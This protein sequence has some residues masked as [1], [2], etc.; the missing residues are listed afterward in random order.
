VHDVYAYGL[1]AQSTLCTLEGY[2]PARAGYAEIAKVAEVGHTVGGE[3]TGSAYV[4]ARLGVGTKLDGSW[5]GTDE[6]SRQVIGLL[7][8]AGVDCS[9]IRLKDDAE[10]IRE[11]V[12]SDSETRTVFGNYGRM[13]G[14][15]R[16]WN[17]PSGDDIRASRTVCLDP[18]LGDESMQAAEICVAAGT[19]YVTIDVAPEGSEWN[20][21]DKNRMR[22]GRNG[23]RAHARVHQQPFRTRVG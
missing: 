9:K 23:M 1:I 14:G 7:S 5:L 19:P 17:E 4:L 21:T 20:G 16:T 3:A 18:F 8:D 6:P 2:F 10:T 15:G 12:F 22:G 13:L 11:F